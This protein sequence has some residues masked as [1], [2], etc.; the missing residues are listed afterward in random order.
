MKK[1]FEGS[2]FNRIEIVGNKEYNHIGC[3]GE[4]EEFGEFL[5]QFVPEVGSPICSR[6]RHE[7]KSKVYN[8]SVRRTKNSGGIQK[9][10]INIS[11]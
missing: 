11:Y 5:V 9:S 4:N 6:S 7:K 8:R 1:T 2:L 3:E 10:K